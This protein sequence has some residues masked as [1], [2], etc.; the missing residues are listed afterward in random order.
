MKPKLTLDPDRLAALRAA[1]T[2]EAM[3]AAQAGTLTAMVPRFGPWNDGIVRTFYDP[4]GPMKA[5]DRERC[6]IALHLASGPPVSLAIHVYR[7]LMEGLTPEEMVQMVGLVAC[8][9]G[10]PR[11][12]SGLEVLHRTFRALEALAAAEPRGPGAIVPGLVRALVPDL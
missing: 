7:G 12:T 6:L 2:P 4:A 8:Y 1:Y 5:Q 11:L 9:A 3:S 10:L